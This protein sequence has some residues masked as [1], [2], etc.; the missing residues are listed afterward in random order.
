LRAAAAGE[1]HGRE[2]ARLVAANLDDFQHFDGV[3]VRSWRG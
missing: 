3:E 2:R 1:W